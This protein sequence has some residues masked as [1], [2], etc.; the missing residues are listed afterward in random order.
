MSA[1]IPSRQPNSPEGSEADGQRDLQALGNMVDLGLGSFLFAPVAY[2][3]PSQRDS[4]ISALRAR[5]SDRNVVTVTLR[6][7]PSDAPSAYSVLDQLEE[8]VRDASPDM[9]PDLLLVLG[10]ET[11]FPADFAE[12]NIPSPALA[13]V[14]QPL[15]LGRSLL[16]AKFPCP[17]ILFLPTAAMAAFLLP[18]LTSTPGGQ[19][20]SRFR[21]IRSGYAGS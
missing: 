9:L 2:D 12:T 5:F 6:P 18:R 13:R 4:V 19:A 21:P 8:R 17:I 20:I 10:L 15:N 3:V 11:L 14:V 7:P 16:A 1:T